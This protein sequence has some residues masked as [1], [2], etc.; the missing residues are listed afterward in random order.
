MNGKLSEMA[1]GDA[2]NLRGIRA[3][4][5]LANP[6]SLGPLRVIGARLTEPT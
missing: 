4:D 6:E 2:I 5:A 3:F 1:A